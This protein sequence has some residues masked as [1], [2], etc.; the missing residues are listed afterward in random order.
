M[1][2]AAHQEKNE[3]TKTGMKKAGEE[4]KDR[5]P[6]FKKLRAALLRSLR[7]QHGKKNGLCE[8]M[9]GVTGILEKANSH[10]NPTQTGSGTAQPR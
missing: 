7:G 9:P 10:F 4:R 6:I 5:Q 3:E 8:G 1:N 2:G